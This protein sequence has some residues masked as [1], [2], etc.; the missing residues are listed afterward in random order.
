MRKPSRARPIQAPAVATPEEIRQGI[1]RLTKR[2]GEVRAFDPTS[3]VEQ[4]NI[5]DVEALA[6]AVDEALIRT[7]GA[8]TLD[9][10]RYS[11]AGYFDNGPFNYAHQVPISQVHASL[12]RSKARSIALLT[13]AIKSLE[14]R[15][16]ESPDT[17]LKQSESEPEKSFERKVFVVHGRDDGPRE[18]VARFLER[19]GFE[20]VIL[21][22]Q[23]NLGR[24]VIEKIEAH[25]DVG[26]AVVLLTPD[27]EGNLKGEPPQPRARQNV[28][29]ELGYF[30]GKLTR[31]RVCTLKEGDLE[32]PSD[33][34]GVIDEPFNSGG[35]WKQT[36]ARELDAAG[37]EIDWNKVMR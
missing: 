17:S 12:N 20:P 9:Y 4:N 36:L 13:Q 5:P 8:D 2:L 19:L 33:W 27:D 6:A 1:D 7:F 30:I 16:A 24:T 29:L 31:E 18:A 21:H 28:L 32:I 3:V 11:D 25:S 37:Y 15:L 10:R 26:F 14:E 22:E 34:R 35:G 23:A